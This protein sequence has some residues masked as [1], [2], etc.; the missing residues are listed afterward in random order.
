VKLDQAVSKAGIADGGQLDVVIEL[1]VPKTRFLAICRN[2]EVKMDFNV[3]NSTKLTEIKDNIM[4]Q[5]AAGT[6][7]VFFLSR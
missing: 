3:K 7:Q 5:L 6:L 4:G 1:K 2:P